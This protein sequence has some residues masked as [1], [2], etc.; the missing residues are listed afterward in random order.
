MTVGAAIAVGGGAT[1][2]VGGP[3]GATRELRV[4]L[5]SAMDSDDI[6]QAWTLS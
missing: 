6:R 5:A 2:A 4:S 3:V 1:I